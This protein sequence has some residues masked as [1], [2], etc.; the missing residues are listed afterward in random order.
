[1]ILYPILSHTL[2]KSLSTTKIT[3]AKVTNHIVT[4]NSFENLVHAIIIKLVDS[5]LKG[6]DVPENGDFE[7]ITG[8]MHHL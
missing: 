2:K 3:V 7:R 5:G 4:W 8:E 6:T 1:M